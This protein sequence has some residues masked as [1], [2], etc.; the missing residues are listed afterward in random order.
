MKNLLRFRLNLG[1]RFVIGVPYLWLLLF[2]VFPFLILLRISVTDMGTGIDPFAPIV[3]TAAGSWR[4]VLRL[5]NYLS[6]FSDGT[7]SVGHTIYVDA[8]TT[9]LKYAALTTVSCLVIGYPF[10]YFM[11][12]ARPSVRPREQWPRP[13]PVRLQPLDG[14]RRH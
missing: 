2:F 7:S 8:Y 4:L 1:R 6:I 13:Q 11:A 3:D 12:R 14:G 9:S 10:A 5:Q